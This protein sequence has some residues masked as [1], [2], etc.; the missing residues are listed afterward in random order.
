MDA[1][2]QK[3]HVSSHIGVHHI[4]PLTHDDD[5]EQELATSFIFK[6]NDEPFHI[7]AGVRHYDHSAFHTHQDVHLHND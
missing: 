2:L 7:A 1:F 3:K 5:L 6:Y 4:S